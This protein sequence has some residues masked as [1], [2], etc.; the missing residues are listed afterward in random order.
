MSVSTVRT[1]TQTNGTTSTFSGTPTVGNRIYAVVYGF[2]TSAAPGDS[3]T[4]SNTYTQIGTDA[5]DASGNHVSLWYSDITHTALN[6]AVN[7]N[8]DFAL[9]IEVTG[10]DTSVT[11][12]SGLIK[13]LKASTSSAITLV[14][15]AVNVTNAGGAV[16][17]ATIDQTQATWSVSAPDT[18]IFNGT[19]QD[20]DVASKHDN[21][22]A[23]NYTPTF[24][25]LAT[26]NNTAAMIAWAVRAPS[27][28]TAKLKRNSSLNG[29]GA[30]GP[31]FHDPLAKS[32]S[33]QRMAT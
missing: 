15:G 24:T 31:F 25:A 26:A 19:P 6:L 11:T 5:V 33:V 10:L 2:G 12:D 32:H 27:S 7:C 13:T 4:P 16:Y 8:S 18:Q 28:G 21:V 30:S 14:S 3:A 17:A 29:L 20:T 22:A 1:A 23:G 9:G